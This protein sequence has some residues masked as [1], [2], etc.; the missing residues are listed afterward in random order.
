MRVKTFFACLLFACL[1]LSVAALAQSSP[2]QP[3]TPQ[4]SATQS[5]AQSSPDAA[6]APG[7]VPVSPLSTVPATAQNAQQQDDSKSKTTFD[8][9]AATGGGNQDQTLGEVRLMTRYTEVGGDQARSFKVPGEN[10]LGEFNYFEDRRFLVTRRIQ[11]LS[12]YRGT[13]DKSIDPEH[14]SLQKA[15]VRVFG[16]RDEY[17]IGDALINYSRLSFNQNIK[18][19]SI[20]HMVGERWKLSGVTGVFIDRWGSLYKDLPNRPYVSGIGA[21]RVE[22]KFLRE[23]NFGF[24]FANSEDMERTLAQ[25]PNGT[26]P[27]PTLNRVISTDTKLAFRNGFRLDGEMAY[28][29]TDFDRR[30]GVCAAPCD[31]RIPQPGL[32]RMQGDWGGRLEDSWR[33]KKLTLR[34]AYVRYEPNFAS[35]QARQISDLQDFDFRAS[36]DLNDWLTLDGAVRRS[37][38]DLKGQLPFKTTLWGPEM[39]FLLHDLSFYPKATFE[40]GYRHR[41][42]DGTFHNVDRFVRTPFAEVNFPVQRMFLTLGYERRQA[43]DLIQATQTSNTNRVYAGLRGIFDVNSWEFNPTFRFELERQSQRPRMAQFPPDFTLDYDSN[44]LDSVGLYIQAPRYFIFEGS[45]RSSSA[46]IF[47]PNGFSRPAYK[48]AV[49]YK[50][51]NDEN[52]QFIFGFERNNN[53]Y[54]TSPNYDERVWSGT[55]LYRFGHRAGQ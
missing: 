47:G 30:I 2:D 40:F 18:G 39:R 54:F 37:N 49:T 21:V 29:F 3:S 38:N 7:S 35:L 34:S 55:I 9:A 46:T 32:N 45:F 25:A 24:N 1:L 31:T 53:F 12:M 36:Y 14:N 17:I 19:A 42:V 33:Y 22:R 44:R 28:S 10:E 20:T 16:P 52:T 5:S 4:T 43:V 23:S 51:K 11:V 50:M 26:S 15:Y 41:A 27:L 13:D 48:A 6:Q 8:T